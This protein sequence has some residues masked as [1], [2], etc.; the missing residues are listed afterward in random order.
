MSY[1]EPSS[2]DLHTLLFRLQASNASHEK[3]K[4]H[5]STWQ[6]AKDL[7]HKSHGKVVD[8]LNPVTAKKNH[9]SQ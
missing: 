9:V 2:H 1:Q 5:K 3:E 6:R 8:V 4:E 7:A